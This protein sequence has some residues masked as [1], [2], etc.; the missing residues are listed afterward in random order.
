MDWITFI[1]WNGILYATYYGANLLVDYLRTKGELT[2]NPSF[3]QYQLKDLGIEEPKTIKSEDV[4]YVNKDPEQTKKVKSSTGS[5]TNDQKN[6][7][8]F[9][10]PIERQGIP[11]RSHRH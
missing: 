7:I 4:L 10:A 2:S 3:T 8:T 5:R 1:K 6:T 9:E 11:V